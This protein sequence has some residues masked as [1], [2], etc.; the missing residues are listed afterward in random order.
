MPQ[1]LGTQASPTDSDKSPDQVGSDL[2]APQM[3]RW[4]VDTCRIKRSGVLHTTGIHRKP[5]PRPHLAEPPVV[6]VAC[7]QVSTESPEQTWMAGH[8]IAWPGSRLR[9]WK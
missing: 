7:P 1:V 2:L 6:L 5:G 3:R 9:A 8:P 4:E